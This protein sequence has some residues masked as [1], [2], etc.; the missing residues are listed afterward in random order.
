[1]SETQHQDVNAAAVA[2]EKSERVVCVSHR[3]PDGD[4][5]G[6]MLAMSIALEAA[7]K[8]VT[9]FCVDPAPKSL[10]F[11]EG[12][13]RMTSDTNVFA[14]ADTVCVFDAGDL[15]FTNTDTVLASLPKKPTIV[16]I[17]HH[18]TN[19]RFGDVNCVVTGAASTTEVVYRI[20]KTLHASITPSMAT[21]LLTGLVVD[22]GLFFNPATSSTALQLAAELQRLGG[23]LK[24]V[25][26]AYS[27]NKTIEALVLWGKV[28][29]RIKFDRVRSHISTVIRL[30]D[31][32]AIP[33]ND[34]SVEGLA[35]FLNS[36]MDARTVLI[37]KEMPD[38]IV[39]GSLRTA[40]ED[41][42]VAAEAL[43]YGGGGHRKAAGFTTRSR[44]VEKENEWT[45]EV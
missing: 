41:V 33:L 26:R 39:K 5:L 4:T 24:S 8:Q 10:R 14:D 19:E 1:M 25:A 38:G 45:L 29:E 20:L 6:G 15:R 16:N 21:M 11:M 34:D 28:L 31:L 35:N 30:D 13:E 40:R 43:R 9:R 36:N 12:A 3:G 42:D 32:D 2:L 37:L 27:K 7:G 44:I 23:D 17:D 22:T 18:A